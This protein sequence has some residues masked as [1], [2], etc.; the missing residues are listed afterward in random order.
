MS[1][2]GPIVVVA[3]K[4]VEGLVKAFADAGAF[5]V[6]EARWADAAGAVASIKPSAVVLAEPAQPEA[7]AA[8]ALTTQIAACEAY[9]PVVARTCENGAAALVNALPVAEDAPVERLIARLTSALRLRTL[10]AT[11]LA[12]A[13]TLQEERNIIA[14]VPPG[15]PLEDATVLVI[16]RGR[17]HPTLSVA[18][19]ERMGVVGAMSVELAVRCLNLRELDGV[20]IGDGLSPK[21]VIS[22]LVVLGEDARYR[23]LPVAMLGPEERVDELPN[24]I[25]ARDPHVLVEQ[26]IPL[27]RQRAFESQLKRLLK[28][29]ESKGMVDV[30]TG[31]LNME[32]FGNALTRAIEDAGERGVGLSVARFSFD[33][34][35]DLRTS[36]N[37]ARLVSRMMRSM[38]FACRQDDGSLVAVFASDLK[39]AHVVA[40]RLASVIR[41]TLLDPER[42]GAPGQAH[43]TLAA[44]KPSDTPITLMSRIAPRTVAAE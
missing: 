32:A 17:Y 30:R 16:G 9:T 22:L 14:E 38:D 23:D 41:H 19:G 15:D 1:L 27:V 36:M 25:H 33:D 26:L 10:H 35:L 11:V 40:R 37:A 39:T 42:R 31:L 5:P 28:S 44:L 13:S 18:V 34:V 21:M 20:V 3:E 6:V 24:F 4:P 12:R 8:Q 29:I 7:A 2:Q 43:V